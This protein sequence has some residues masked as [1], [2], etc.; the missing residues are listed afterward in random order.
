MHKRLR[1]D[2]AELASTSTSLRLT[3]TDWSLCLICRENKTEKLTRPDQTKRKDIGTGYSSLTENLIKFSELG[4]LSFNLERLNDGH[5]IEVAMVAH[6]AQY[7]QI[8]RL[9]YNNAKLQRAQMRALK[10]EDQT[11][12]E[13]SACKRT[14]AHSDS[15]SKEIS[16]T[17]F[18]CGQSPVNKSLRSA[19]MCNLGW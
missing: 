2:S 9:Q 5:G 15:L 8:C 1:L 3:P 18:F 19:R 11:D 16:A 7:H 6:G 10:K 4:E 14:R 12:E 17:C 13:G